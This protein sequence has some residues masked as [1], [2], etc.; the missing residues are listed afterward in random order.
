LRFGKDNLS[1]GKADKNNYPSFKSC[2]I[3]IPGSINSKYGAKVKIVQKWNGVRA[4]ITREFIEDFRTY[5][6]QKITDQGNNNYNY[7]KN[8]NNQNRYYSNNN[9]IEW[10]ETKVLQAPISDYRKLAV[11]LIL[12]PYLIVIKKLSHEESY[13]ITNE[14]LQKCDSVS[15]RIL[16]FDPKYLINNSL[17]T[18]AKKLIPSI[19]LYKLKTNYPCLYFLIIDQKKRKNEEEEEKI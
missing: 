17:K 3:R 1:K 19:S 7:K 12:A 15:G 8:K 9:R 14:W 18:S 11:R 4:P 6:E 13:K 2:Q 5:L 10:I 16:D